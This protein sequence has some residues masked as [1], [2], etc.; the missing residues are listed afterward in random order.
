MNPEQELERLSAHYAALSEPELN[1][2]GLTYDTLTVPAQQALRAEFERRGMPA[3][4]I[5][6]SES[7][8]WLPLVTI[9]QFTE[10]PEALLA[11][12]VLESAGIEASLSNEN[13]VRMLWKWSNVVGGVGLQ[14][15]AGD[16][17]TAEE[18]LA[19]PI[20]A[21]LQVDEEDYE[22]PACPHC[23]SLDI[24]FEGINTRVGLASIILLPVPVPW[25]KQTWSC[26]TCGQTW[27]D[28]PESSA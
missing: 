15:R 11:K 23:Q 7:S 8:G 22:Q 5:D 28:S 19:Q 16:V 10:I 9:R 27:R 21:T 24:T 13:M 2:L 12:S 1:E 20:P 17:E 18:I 4:L 25:P 14:V 26:H 6:D 3:P